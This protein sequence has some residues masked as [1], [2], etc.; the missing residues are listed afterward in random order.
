[1][2]TSILVVGNH[3]IT[4][5]YGG[6]SNFNAVTSSSIT[7]TV[8]AVAAT[9]TATSSINPSSF[10]QSVDFTATVTGAG[11]T[12]TGTVAVTDGAT[13]LGTITLNASGSGVLTTATLTG[14]S[15]SLLFTYSGDS[16][17]TH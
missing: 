11:A 14:G 6:D 4:V 17:Y 16:N 1:M 8:N 10:G 3:P 7:Q 13:T 2:A 5:Q 15:H 9:V 12:P